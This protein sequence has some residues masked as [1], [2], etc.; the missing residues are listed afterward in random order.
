V[1]TDITVNKGS[2]G[3]VK[4]F[5][6]NLTN[7][8]LT[9]KPIEND[10]VAGD[11]KG[12]PAIILD[13]NSYAPT[14]SLKRFMVP[15]SN[16]TIAA[17]ATQEVDVTIRVPSTAQAGGYFGAIRFAP[18]VPG[19]NQNL[20]V[21]GSVASLI[22][23]TVPGDLVETLLLTNFDVQ[24]DGGS[25]TNFRT[26]DHLSLFVRF[27]N[28]GNV[29][30]E[31]FGQIYV[32]KGKKV[33]YTYTFNG[34]DP[35]QSVLPDSARRWDVPLKGLGKFGKYTVGATF[36]YGS[37][38]T[39]IEI[40]KTIWIIPTAYILITIGII[41][42]L[43]LLVFGTWKFLKGYKKRIL[44]ESNRN[45]HRGGGFG[46]SGGSFG[47]G[48]RPNGGNGSSSS[49][50]VTQQQGGYPPRGP[51]SAAPQRPAGPSQ[52]GNSNGSSYPPRREGGSTDSF[53]GP[54][55]RF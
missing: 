31:P 22:L 24:Q 51:A 14:H 39:S 38:G 30:V 43:I 44:R 29:Q 42:F 18:V 26:P 12:T 3:S 5:V 33:L 4:T 1:R 9:V 11:E 37:K 19:G 10:F 47:P 13:E 49:H 16:V 55:R 7:S 27:Q 23:M 8:P 35:K 40:K 48:S 6:T 36:T 21:S 25:G 52:S 34:K 41:V 50:N 53:G 20:S 15:L 45:N 54:R 46:P 32:Q 28:K 2:S 17:K